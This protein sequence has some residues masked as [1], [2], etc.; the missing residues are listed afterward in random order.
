MTGGGCKER[1]GE[2]E[3]AFSTSETLDGDTV[4]EEALGET[5]PVPGP[6]PE[7][8][9]VACEVKRPECDPPSVR[10]GAQ[11]KET[12]FPRE[13]EGRGEKIGVCVGVM[14]ETSL[15]RGSWEALR[16]GVGVWHR[17]AM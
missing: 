13:S 15:G 8:E 6:L 10:L 1:D 2:R 17:M 16:V 14:D 12:L 7:L 3:I 4:E 9:T 11:D 5:Y